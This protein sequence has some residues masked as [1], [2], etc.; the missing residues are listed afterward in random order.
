MIVTSDP[1]VAEV[2]NIFLPNSQM[3]TTSFKYEANEPNSWLIFKY[4]ICVHTSS[5]PYPLS[6]Q[7]PYVLFDMFDYMI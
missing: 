6:L 3:P 2:K 4:V 5:L 1:F 7:P